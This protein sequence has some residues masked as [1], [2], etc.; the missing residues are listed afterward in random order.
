MNLSAIE[1]PLH[2]VIPITGHK[3]EFNM[4]SVYPDTGL[5]L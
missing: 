1:L 4:C 5:S 2:F 3:L